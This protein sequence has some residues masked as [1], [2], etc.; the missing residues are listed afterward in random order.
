MTLEAPLVRR[1]SFQSPVLT[2]TLTGLR[3]PVAICVVVTME[4]GV[5]STIPPSARAASAAALMANR[6]RVRMGSPSMPRVSAERLPAPANLRG[7]RTPANRACRHMQGMLAPGSPEQKRVPRAASVRAA[8][9][10]PSNDLRKLI[11]VDGLDDE[12]GKAG[13]EQPV[14]AGIERQSSHRHDRYA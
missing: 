2:L 3:V 13:F 14:V 8:R 9:A 11:G 6:N 10:I 5:A 4:A 12:A 7:H 1:S